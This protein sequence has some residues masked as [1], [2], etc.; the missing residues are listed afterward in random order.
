[1]IA[2]SSEQ[3][4]GQWLVI[5]F[6]GT[7]NQDI[8]LQNIDNENID[9]AFCQDYVYRFDIADL[10][11]G[12]YNICIAD[13]LYLPIIKD[14]DAPINI[15]ARLGH[16]DEATTDNETNANLWKFNKLSNLYDTEIDSALAVEA[17]SAAN[18][19]QVAARVN[20][21]KKRWKSTIS[22]LALQNA[23]SLGTLHLLR[24]GWHSSPLFNIVD[25]YDFYIKIINSANG[26]LAESEEF[27]LIKKYVNEHAEQVQ[28]IRRCA[29]GEKA[30][31]VS[32]RS[33]VGTIISTQQPDKPTILV[34]AADSTANVSALWQNLQQKRYSGFL[35]LADVPAAISGNLTYNII[36]GNI[37]GADAEKLRKMQPVVLSVDTKGAILN[38]IPFASSDDYALY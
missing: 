38:F 11:Y 31:D 15:C 28:F 29:D 37:V 7:I 6:N 18:R 10:D 2:C 22:N 19:K 26:K 8:Y 32:L 13:S 34:F 20:A 1:M 27:A 5:D 21:V 36:R 30:P 35:L 25:D 16:L 3:P 33:R 24:L 4:D 23:G 9:T 12:L 14:T 17:P